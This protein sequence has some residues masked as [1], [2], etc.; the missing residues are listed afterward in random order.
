M[1]GNGSHTDFRETTFARAYIIHD[2]YAY[3]APKDASKT[4]QINTNGF[5]FLSEEVYIDAVIEEGGSINIELYTFDHKKVEGIDVTLEK[6]DHR[7]RWKLGHPLNRQV[8]RLMLT[9]NK[10]K[11]YNFQGDI[12]IYRVEDDNSLLRL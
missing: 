4:A 11:I 5:V 9:L 2:R 10:S 6:I 1:G 8:V 7:Y 3:I 12:E